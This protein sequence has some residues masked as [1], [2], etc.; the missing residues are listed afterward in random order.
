MIS[1]D[2]AIYSQKRGLAPLAL[3]IPTLS[4]LRTLGGPDA[5]Q[6]QAAKTTICAIW[7]SRPRSE[8]R[9]R[10]PA[11]RFTGALCTWI[12]LDDAS[13]GDALP[14]VS[15]WTSISSHDRHSNGCQCIT[16]CFAIY[17]GRR[18]WILA[19]DFTSRCVFNGGIYL[20]ANSLLSLS[21]AASYTDKAYNQPRNVSRFSAHCGCTDCPCIRASE[22]VEIVIQSATTLSLGDGT[23]V[24]TGFLDAKMAFMWWVTLLGPRCARSVAL[25]DDPGPLRNSTGGRYAL[26]TVV[27][28]LAC[29]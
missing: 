24:S 19:Q 16:D 28:L 12:W 21:R 3:S 6:A 23:P 14:A 18:D 27:D 20:G 13:Q 9:Y 22:L 25:Q 29:G 26:T 1:L 8:K 11:K 17:F 5:T 2:F 15:L 7:V 10:T 4:N